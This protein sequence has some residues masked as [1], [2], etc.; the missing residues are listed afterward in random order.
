MRRTVADLKNL[1]RTTRLA[2]EKL[3]AAEKDARRMAI[4]TGAQAQLDQHIDTLNQRLGANWLPRV[5]GG[6]GEVIKGKK[7]LA[8]MEDAVAVALTSAKAEIGA[9]WPSAWRPTVSTWCKRTAT[10][11]LFC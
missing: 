8:N 7:S 9:H 3:V 10:G 2:T 11:L 4:V 6:F 5:A 1:A